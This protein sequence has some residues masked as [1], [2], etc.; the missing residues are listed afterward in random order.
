MF[1]DSIEQNDPRKPLEL[2][3]HLSRTEPPEQAPEPHHRHLAVQATGLLHRRTELYLAPTE[4]LEEFR[5]LVRGE[6]ERRVHVSLRLA[7]HSLH[8]RQQFGPGEIDQPG[9]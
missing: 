5:V 6:Q 4:R 2:L 9:L 7:P 8:H 3:L 1:S